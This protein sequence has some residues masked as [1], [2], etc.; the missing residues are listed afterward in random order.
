MQFARIV[1]AAAVAA[2]SATS[3]FA[4]QAQTLAGDEIDVGIFRTVD[5]GYGL[6]RVLGYGLDGPFTVE[7]GFGDA[8]T[9]S[10]C[11]SY[12]TSR[13]STLRWTSFPSPAG[14]RAPSSE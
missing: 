2:L 1:R 6:G 12:S 8:K 9:Y 5:T 14:R 7:N 3:I 4:A 11:L 10:K 13:R